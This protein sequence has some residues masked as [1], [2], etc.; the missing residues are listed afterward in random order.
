VRINRGLVFWGVALIT[1]GAVALAIQAGVIDGEVARQWWRL[2]P[3]ALIVIGIAIIAARTQFAIV[4]TLAAGLVVGGLGGSLVGGFPEGLSVGCGGEVDQSLTE[5]GGFGSAADVELDFN[6][7]DLAVAMG[8]GSDWAVDAGYAGDSRPSVASGDGSL[9]VS[10]EGGGFPFN[11]GRQEWQVTLPTEVDL[12]LRVE[13]NAA[14]SELD[15][16]GGSFSELG[17]DTNA[18]SVTMNLAGAAADELSIEMNAGSVQ[19]TADDA[20]EF[21]GTVEMN[22]GSLEVCIPDGV[23]FAITVAEGNI[24]FSHNLDESGLSRSGDT[25]RSG[26]GAEAITLTVEG[27]AA[28]FTL[29]PE[30]GCS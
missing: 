3:V 14:S 21:D 23:V 5:E 13:A 1:A 24:T 18:G 9:R 20:T 6:C 27:N 11:D 22:A 17:L 28:S 8:G 2:W 15:L 7:G 4:G 19:L 25:W 30:E 12:A 26:S 29:N 10:S 16:E